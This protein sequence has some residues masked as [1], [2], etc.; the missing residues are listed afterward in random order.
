MESLG[1]LLWSRKNATHETTHTH[2]T[3]GTYAS[4]SIYDKKI[5][6]ERFYKHFP[7]LVRVKCKIQQ[8][9]KRTAVFI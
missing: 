3:H 8:R 7:L 6:Y 9:N 4:K 5:T 2:Q 1:S